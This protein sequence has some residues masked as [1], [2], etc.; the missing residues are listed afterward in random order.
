VDELIERLRAAAEALSQGD[1]DPFASLFAE[2]A[3]WRGVPHGHLWRKR[4]PS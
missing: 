4:T 3:E 1:S 2:D